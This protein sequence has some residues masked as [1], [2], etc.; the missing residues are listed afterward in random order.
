MAII[1]FSSMLM[2]ALVSLLA[3]TAAAVND[4]PIIGVFT[5]PSSES[6][7]VCKGKCE[8]LAASY[9][10]YLESSGARVG[11]FL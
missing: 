4:W 8:Y 1:T 7:S 3:S 11:R 10:K 9:V 2:I 5:Q 6:N